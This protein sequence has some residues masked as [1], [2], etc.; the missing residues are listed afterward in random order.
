M[1]KKRRALYHKAPGKETLKARF[2][3]RMGIFPPSAAKLSIHIKKAVIPCEIAAFSQTNR[4]KLQLVSHFDR[5]ALVD[6]GEDT[7]QVVDFGQ[8]VVNDIGIFGVVD[9][10]VLMV[11]LRLIKAL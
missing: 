3:G 10:E 5:Y 2:G 9:Q 4:P 1:P 8:V 11:I 6:F 7:L